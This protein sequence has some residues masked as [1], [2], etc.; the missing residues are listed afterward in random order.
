MQRQL[1][2]IAGPEAGRTFTLVDGQ[3][4]VVGR[5]EKSDTR[6]NDPRISRIHCISKRTADGRC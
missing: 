5:G 6:I 2:V 4:L 3:T 1:I